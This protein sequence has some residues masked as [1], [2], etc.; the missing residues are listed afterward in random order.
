MALDPR[1]ILQAGQ[2]ADIMGAVGQGN[3]LAQ[4]TMEMRNQNA[5]RDIYR[6][7]GAGLVSGNQNALTA[8]AGL[9][10]M[11]AMN[12]QTQ[13]RNNA[14]ADRQL[15]MQEQQHARSQ[16]DW[17]MKLDTH[18]RGLNAE[19][20][21]TESA[22]MEK[23][24]SGAA[25]FYQT[26]NKQGYDQLLQQNGL[27]PAQYSFEQFPAYAARYAPVL[28]AY[29]AF[30][31]AEAS[32]RP[33]TAEE[34][35]AYGAQGG[36]FG[37]DGR[38]YPINPPSG[39]SI[40]TGPDGA[41]RIVQGPGAG[42]RAATFTEGQSKDVVYSTRARGAL[43]RLDPVADALTS[44]GQRAAGRD[45]TG[46]VRGAVQS[47]DFQLAQQAADEFLQAV[48]RKDT[49]AAIT[50]QEMD[51]YGR[52]YLPQPGDGTAVLQQKQEARHRALAAME[53]GMGPEQILA[54]ERALGSVNAATSGHDGV[55][56][57]SDDAGYDALPSGSLFKGPDGV[58]RRK[59]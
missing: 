40:E 43:G 30:K 37:A 47:N 52:T 54:Q 7:H 17:Q 35:A 22:E 14:R 36:Q 18:M 10:P 49:G 56:A 8:L 1:L 15:G 44:A 34:A 16:Q 5:L 51:E 9:D 58:T 31:P 55:A 6:E 53:A 46:V 41:T 3:A 26:G 25:W 45:P 50:S 59:P 24:L 42:N 27:D 29:K 12:V 2:T 38:F 39:M 4:Q 21:A 23:V 20:L 32:F 57:I 19:Q 28:D 11:A 33:A 13:H 48:L